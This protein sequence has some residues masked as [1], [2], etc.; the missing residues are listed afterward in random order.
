M[1]SGNLKLLEL[2]RPVQ[3]CGGIDLLLKDSQLA[4]E[5]FSECRILK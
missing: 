1:I 4:A 3:A 2:S 5:Y